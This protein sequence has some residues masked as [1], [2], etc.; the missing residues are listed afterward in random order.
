[1]LEVVLMIFI[2]IPIAC[3]LIGDLSSVCM[4]GVGGLRED[5]FSFFPCESSRRLFQFG[6]VLFI[7]LMS[8][9]FV[10]IGMS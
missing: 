7:R 1:M 6:Q 9:T 3:F 10:S 4:V 5:F 8:S 2:A